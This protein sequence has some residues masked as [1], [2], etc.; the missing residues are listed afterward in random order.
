MNGG[1]TIF[2]PG[3]CSPFNTKHTMRRFFLFGC[4]AFL[5]SQVALRIPILTYILPNFVWYNA[6][7]FTPWLNALF[8][9]GTAGIFEEG[10]RLIALRL[11]LKRQTLENDNPHTTLRQGIAFGLGHGGIEAFIFVG[12]N[13]LV[14]LFT[15]FQQQ[16]LI[17][18][19]IAWFERLFAI[20]F[21]VGAT[22]IVLYGL[23]VGRP[24]LY[25]AIATALHTLINGMAILL[26]SL[27]QVDILG[28]ELAIAVFGT[29]TLCGGI[30]LH[31][32]LHTLKT[33]QNRAE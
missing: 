33:S 29:L 2:S 1:I 12:L 32:H 25:T 14:A 26:P 24:L 7:Q 21:H 22:L 8:L 20:A 5:V 3:L 17:W 11:L 30:Y 16:T 31:K 19:G 9:G 23:K 28:L 27:W 10:A 4:I 13:T 18:L 15:D 6:L